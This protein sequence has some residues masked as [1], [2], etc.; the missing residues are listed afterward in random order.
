MYIYINENE[1]LTNYARL[2]V[3]AKV[4]IYKTHP[5]VF[6]II[7]IKLSVLFCSIETKFFYALTC[8]VF[9]NFIHCHASWSCT[10]T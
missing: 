6:Y 10:N 5:T 2:C 4:H 3:F 7:A 9:A 1:S 8:N